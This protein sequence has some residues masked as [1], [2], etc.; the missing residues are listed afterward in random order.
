MSSLKHNSI[1]RQ[2]ARSTLCFLPLVAPFVQLSLGQSKS[3]LKLTSKKDRDT[4]LVR[5]WKEVKDKDPAGW[6]NSVLEAQERLARFGYGTTFTAKLDDKTKEALRRFQARN[7]LPVTGDLDFDTWSHIQDDD[8]ALN[9]VIPMGP[10]YLFNDSDW[11]NIFTAEGVWLEQ[12]KEPDATT[13]VRSSRIECF[14][15]NGMCIV[16]T[17]TGTL[18][19]LQYMDIERWDEYEIAT[20]P[21]DLPCGREFIQISR[22]EKAVITTNTAAYKDVEAVRSCL[23]HQARWRYLICPTPDNL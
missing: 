22:P 12:G 6:A 8:I 13:P 4:E 3:S 10:A 7:N 11:N 2:L 18:I 17:N 5:M 21:D 20:R 1:A 9:R 14:K 23:G 15:A 19:H 16:A